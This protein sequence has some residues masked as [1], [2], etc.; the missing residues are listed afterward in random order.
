M[1][2]LKKINGILDSYANDTLIDEESRKRVLNISNSYN[3]NPNIFT[4]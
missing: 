1:P 3:T 4:C 2:H